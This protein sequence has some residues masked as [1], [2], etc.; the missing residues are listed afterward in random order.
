MS[1]GV[2]RHIDN[3]DIGHKWKAYG[4]TN[5]LTYNMAKYGSYFQIS[6]HTWYHKIDKP[7]TNLTYD[8]L[9]SVANCVNYCHFF[10]ITFV[11]KLINIPSGNVRRY[12]NELVSLRTMGHLLEKKHLVRGHYLSSRYM[13]GCPQ[14]HLWCVCNGGIRIHGWL[15]DTHWLN[16]NDTYRFFS[17]FLFSFF[18]FFFFGGGGLSGHLDNNFVLCENNCLYRTS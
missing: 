7:T 9:K 6:H 5:N 14:L 3:V 15:E 8:M 10:N 13:P 2:T 1:T 16:C 11:I 4:I 12:V 18:F 17:F